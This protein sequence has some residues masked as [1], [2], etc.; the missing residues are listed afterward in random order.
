VHS[1]VGAA[2]QPI[3]IMAFP[4]QEVRRHAIGLVMYKRAPSNVEV[5]FICNSIRLD[6]AA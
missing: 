1:R 5:C 4:D 2:L 6:A 3:I